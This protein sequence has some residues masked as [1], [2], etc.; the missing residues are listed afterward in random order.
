[1]IELKPCPFCGSAD[2][3]ETS[4]GI[5][6]YFHECNQC[7]A[8]G[9][10]VHEGPVANGWNTRPQPPV[11]EPTEAMLKAGER[12]LLA[13]RSSYQGDRVTLE[14]IY[15]AMQSAKAQE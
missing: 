6:E 9:P 13:A 2:I 7:G 3:F 10:V 14:A 15:T 5:N 4:N 8:R 11:D 1:M 12:E